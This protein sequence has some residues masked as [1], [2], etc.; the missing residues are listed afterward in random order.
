MNAAKVRITN[1]CGILG[2]FNSSAKIDPSCFSS[3]LTTLSHRGPDGEG[4]SYFSDG[5]SALGHRRLAVIDLTENGKQPMCNEDGSI[6]ITCNGEIYNYRELRRILE[7]KGHRFSSHSDTE[8]IV[9]GYEE[10]GEHCVE[11]LR[12]MFAFGIWDDAKQQL[13]LA[14]DHFGIKPLYYY[15]DP[16]QFIFASELKA[17]IACPQ[18]Q[19]TL[20]IPAICDFFFYRYIPAPRTIWDGVSKLPPASLLIYRNGTCTVRRYWEPSFEERKTDEDTALQ[21]LE[22]ALT[23]SVTMHLVSDVPLGLLLSGGLDS[24][25]IAFLMKRE[26]GRAVAFSA[27]F[28]VE[29][30]WYNEI[31][32]ARLVAERCSMDLYEE[33]VK[34]DI[35]ELLPRLSWFYDEP[36]GDGSMFPSYLVSRLARKHMKV[37]LAGDGG[38]ELFAGYNRYFETPA[39]MAG[40]TRINRSGMARGVSAAGPGETRVY[41]KGMHP[42]LESED[43]KHLL[44]A[45]IHAEIDEHQ[46]W[47]LDQHYR[48]DLP[49]PKR[50]QALDFLTILPEQYLTKVD[51]AS[52]ANSLELRVPF[53]DKP[54]VEFVFGLPVDAFAPGGER[55]YMLKKLMRGKLPER[56]L[57]KKKRGF[58]IP[59]HHYFNENMLLNAL[60]D[61]TGVKSGLIRRDYVIGL[62]RQAN[63]VS[64]NRLWQIALFDAWYTRWAHPS[65]GKDT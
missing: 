13:I 33:M 21:D 61:G 18:V 65:F 54:L 59:L 23:D 20:N 16:A 22:A 44:H 17:I 45:D 7:T 38:D 37:A 62:A 10:W 57:T 3:M 8:V 14:R 51:R 36:F 25:A 6:W 47:F 55:K 19:R 32:D 50:W 4:C 9:H 56:T 39:V 5:C 12:G 24:S 27:G 26:K 15:R 60:M 63:G 40:G 49:S 29:D 2:Q 35:W 48:P 52:M 42:L 43:L 53:L 34:P 28:A 58:S 31:P 30:E 11:R 1:M 64:L 46:E 41:Q